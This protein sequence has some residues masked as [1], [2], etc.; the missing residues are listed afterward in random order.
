MTVLEFIY[1]N[2]AIGIGC[3]IGQQN[4]YLFDE[5]N[6]KFDQIDWYLC[7]IEMKRILPAVFDMA[8]KPV[9][10]TFFGSI[11]ASRDTFKTVCILQNLSSRYDS[12]KSDSNNAY[13]DAYATFRY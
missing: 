13:D 5:I 10:L 7:P 4:C 12:A 1:V 6:D 8:Q 9:Y 11:T 3:E 2:V